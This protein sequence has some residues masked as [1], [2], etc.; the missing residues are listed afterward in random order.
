MGLTNEP[1]VIAIIDDD[2]PLREALGNLIRSCGFRT[3]LFASAQDYL[4]FPRCER[5]DLIVTDFGMPV[6]SGLELLKLLRDRGDEMP[7]ILI[8][9]HADDA[10]VAQTLASGGTACLQK[11]FDADALL[12]EIDRGLSH[13]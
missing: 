11:P 8:S 2:A 9:A 1:A 10:L 7:V 6:M 12:T 4:V 3:I 13:H 5:I